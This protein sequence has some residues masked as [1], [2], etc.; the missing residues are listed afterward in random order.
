MSATRLCVAMGVVTA[1]IVVLC[2]PAVA[3]QRAARLDGQFEVKAKGFSAVYAFNPVGCGRSAPCRRVH[4]NSYGFVLTLTRRSATTFAGRR[5]LRNNYPEYKC[6][7]RIDQRVSVRVL[8]AA[9]VGGVVQAVLIRVLTT[10]TTTTNCPGRPHVAKGTLKVI[11]KQVGDM[12]PDSFSADVTGRDAHVNSPLPSPTASYRL[13]WGEPSS[14]AKNLLTGRSTS[15]QLDASHRYAHAGSYVVHLTVIDVL[16]EKRTLSKRLSIVLH[17]PTAS[18][19]GADGG[20][21]AGQQVYLDSGAQDSDG[22]VVAYSWDFGDGS[23][24]AEASP[25]HTWSSPGTYT[26]TLVVTD[27]DGLTSAPATAQIVIQPAP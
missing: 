18:I 12:F 21:L 26:I 11:G 27:N 9:S 22:T 15:G 13:D 3:A 19:Q 7:E 1:C 24:S 16:G 17:R 5:V 6:F 20:G 4:Y 10:E 14:G 23:H 2:A 8:R 25:A